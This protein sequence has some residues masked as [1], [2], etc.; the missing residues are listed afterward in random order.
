[1]ELVFILSVVLL[2]ILFVNLLQIVE[3]VRAVR[4]YT[5]MEDEVFPFLLSHKRIAAVRAAKGKLL[6]ETVF[7]GREVRTTDLAAKLPCCCGRDKV[8]EHRRKGNS[9]H[10]GCH[11]V[12]A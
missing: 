5:F 1:M 4:I 11:R 3:I 10:R 7:S 8:W 12:C 6:G 9:S 2:Q